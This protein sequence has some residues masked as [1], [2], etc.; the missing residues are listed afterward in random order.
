MSITMFLLAF[1]ASLPCLLL[2]ALVGHFCIT[3]VAFSA[4]VLD[5]FWG[6]DDDCEMEMI[7]AGLE[8]V[9]FNAPTRN[10]RDL[11]IKVHIPKIFGWQM[12]KYVEIRDF[13]M[14]EGVYALQFE[15]LMEVSDEEGP[16]PVEVGF[17]VRQ[18]GCDIY[19]TWV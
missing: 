3:P 14:D 15:D 10:T 2:L 13:L 5:S 6:L 1:C 16:V 11:D 9:F 18:G 12:E 19:H 4:S 8:D 17:W 7:E